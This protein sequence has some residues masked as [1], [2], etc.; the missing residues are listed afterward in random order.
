MHKPD[1]LL[2]LAIVILLGALTTSF[3]TEPQRPA[4][5]L[6]MESSIR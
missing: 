5:L 2:L 1:A 3:S 4:Q 6:T